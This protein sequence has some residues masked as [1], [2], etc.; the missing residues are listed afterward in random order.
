[1]SDL[2]SR[3]SFVK[4]LAASSVASLVSKRHLP[5][6]VE[7]QTQKPVFDSRLLIQPFDYDCVRL[8]DGMLKRQF[9]QTRDFYFSIP[10]DDILKGF[11]Q[12]A[13]LR[14]PGND[15]GGWYS[16]DPKVTYW[17]S[18][19]DTFNVFG[20]WLSGMARLSKAGQD[21][22][23][24]NKAVH[25]MIEWSKT[26][27]DD[28][29]FFYSRHPNAPHYIY[30]KMVCGLI[31]ISQFCDRKDALVFLERITDWAISN[32]DRIRQPNVGST[33]WY[34]LSENLY[35]AYVIT[36]NPKYK[37]FAE[38]WLYP[39][40]WNFFTGGSSARPY[41]YH[42]YSHVNTLSSAAMAYEVTGDPHYLAVI[43][44]AYDWLE[45][46]QFYA[47]G[48]YGPEEE[49]LPPDGSLS[50][51]LED[52][53]RSFETICGSWAAFKL[54][55]YLMQFTGE[56]RYGDWIENV[57]YNAIGAALP[58]TGNGQTFYYSDYRMGGA[59][60]IYHLDGTWPCCS[61]TFP[62]V[63]ADYHNVIYFKDK[64]G[65][66]VNLFVPSTVAWQQAET[67]VSVI[68]ETAY[69]ESETSRLI[70]NPSH[71]V[72]F[73]LRIRVPKWATGCTLYVN[74]GKLSVG[75]SPGKW[76]SILRTWHP[77][78]R[79]D[80]ELPMSVRCIP[81]DAQHPNR[82]ALA[83]GPVVLV[84]TAQPTLPLTKE[85]LMKRADSLTFSGVQQLPQDFLPFYRI[86]QNVPYNMYFDVPVN[87]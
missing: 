68:Q 58:M 8:S 42:A 26:I 65:I 10:D 74:K 9:R 82:V 51:S 61:G 76:T 59:R 20:Q 5:G 54:S 78:D 53:F 71:P 52:S 27:E 84:Q 17:W 21:E 81:V 57:V 7:A 14:A 75:S 60:K 45:R 66:Y 19:G 79:V 86:G 4:T 3:R 30:D 37:N 11:R 72:E 56:A 28:G 16:G 48:G 80:I 36:G 50:K 12:R 35:R 38:V 40:Y 47:T 46:T 6:D 2:S 34:T 44:K 22:E 87:G 83:Y 64:N 18:K 73:D 31:D 85:V 33:E 70:V 32:L 24:K 13:G 29:Y 25:L 39:A 69:P 77:G 43:T 55:R 41:R 23:L 67:N 63:V 15:L 62:Q 49:I 1:M